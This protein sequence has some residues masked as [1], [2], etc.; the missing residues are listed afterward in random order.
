LRTRAA[1]KRVAGGARRCFSSIAAPPR[2]SCHHCHPG[3]RKPFAEV[4]AFA[5]AA[6]QYAVNVL[7]PP[8]HHASQPR[9]PDARSPSAYAGLCQLRAAWTCA[10]TIA[11]VSVGSLPSAHCWDPHLDGHVPAVICKPAAA[12]RL[13]CSRRHANN[14]RTR[15]VIKAAAPLVDTK[16]TP[17]AAEQYDH[18]QRLNGSRST[19]RSIATDQWRIHSVVRNRDGNTVDARELGGR[20]WNT[21]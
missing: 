2:L 10:N 6:R 19:E 17:G 4:L 21:G 18:T 13:Y 5:T 14:D 8:P 16:H 1:S 12:Q 11:T 7:A 3:P 9:S 15:A 20:C